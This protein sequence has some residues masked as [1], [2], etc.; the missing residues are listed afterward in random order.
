VRGEDSIE[1]LAR[2]REL[3]IREGALRKCWSVASRE[4]ELVSLPE[5]DL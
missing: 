3:W 5:R 1:R 4:E 2:G